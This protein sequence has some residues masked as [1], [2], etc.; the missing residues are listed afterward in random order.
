MDIKVRSAKHAHGNKECV[1]FLRQWLKFAERGTVNHVALA[2]HSEPNEIFADSVGTIGSQPNVCAALTALAKRIDKNVTERFAPQDAS[3]GADQVTFCISTGTVSYD[4]IPWLLGAE[5]HRIRN[6]APA[7]L[8]VC[9]FQ[10]TQ[11]NLRIPEHQHR[12]MHHVVGPLVDTV[13]GIVNKVP[14]GKFD[15]SI[16]YND[17]VAR[18]RRG[19]QIPQLCST[20]AALEAVDAMLKDIPPPIVITLREAEHQ[21][22]RNSNLGEWLRFAGDLVERGEEV[23]FVR[24]TAKADEEFDEFST[25][26]LAS[27]NLHIRLALYQRAKFNLFVANGPAT[28]NFHIDTPFIMMSEIDHNRIG[29]YEPAWPEWWKPRMGIEAGEQFPWFKA[30]QRI[31][32]QQDTYA[33]ISAA[34]EARHG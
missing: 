30:N 17:I 15:F 4:F 28:L 32:W 12:M 11:Q 18:Y 21:P 27:H 20:P 3:V 34:W 7:P 5:M 6:G 1:E 9:F 22:Q 25:L 8:K 33:N 29:T 26:P 31:V 10:V 16:T 14:G 23:I 13:G 2:I 24:D 19:E